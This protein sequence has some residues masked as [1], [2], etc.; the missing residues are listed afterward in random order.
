MAYNNRIGGNSPDHR[1]LSVTIFV[2]AAS[3][4]SPVNKGD[5]FVLDATNGDYGAKRAVDGDIPLYVAK[6][7]GVV[8]PDR[9]VGAF[10][11]GGKQRIHQLPYTGTAPTLG[12]SVVA[13]GAS[14]V[15]ATATPNATLVLKVDTVR[16]IVEVLI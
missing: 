10:L 14:T 11:I 9:P 16:Q 4:A 7:G 15:K 2:K 12:A 8:S 1:G 6:H 13:S 5:L 3:V